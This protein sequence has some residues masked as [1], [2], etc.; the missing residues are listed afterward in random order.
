MTDLDS[1]SSR[2]SS[3]LMI[4]EKVRKQLESNGFSLDKNQIGV[5]QA[6]FLV[7]DYQS[8]SEEIFLVVN[9]KNNS[10]KWECQEW[11]TT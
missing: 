10:I 1:T 5:R 7:I 11:E 3:I 4:Q 2:A 9:T 8:K 6:I